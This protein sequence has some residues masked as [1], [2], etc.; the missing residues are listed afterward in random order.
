MYFRAMLKPQYYDGGSD[1]QTILIGF[2]ADG[3]PY[4]LIKIDVVNG[5]CGPRRE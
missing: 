2:G 1:D 4:N 5:K 3:K